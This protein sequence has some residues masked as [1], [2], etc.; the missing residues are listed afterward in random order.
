MINPE[1]LIRHY[2][3]APRPTVWLSAAN[4]L[5][6]AAGLGFAGAFK[7][8]VGLIAKPGKFAAR[9]VRSGNSLDHYNVRAAEDHADGI[10]GVGA[11]VV[12]FAVQGVVAIWAIGHSASTNVSGPSYVITTGY[13][14]V[15]VALVWLA[16]RSSRKWLIWRYL[17]DLARYPN[18]S[19]EALAA[20][21]LVE[22]RRYGRVL[23]EGYQQRPDE[24]DACYARRVWKIEETTE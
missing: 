12:G 5:A 22:L 11:L 2:S 15:S 9:I 14:I 24:D 4:W 23:G 19:E 6:L 20:P 3:I 21:N 1:E 13:F 18:Y 16:G 7:L 17:V 10:V 8:A